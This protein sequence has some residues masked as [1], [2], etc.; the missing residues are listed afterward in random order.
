MAI[1]FRHRRIPYEP[2]P[3]FGKDWLLKRTA[4]EVAWLVDHRRLKDETD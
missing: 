4:P 3:G 1:D 2:D